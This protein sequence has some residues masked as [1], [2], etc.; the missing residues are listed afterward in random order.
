MV[1]IFWDAR[2]ERDLTRLHAERFALEQA[3]GEDPTSIADGSNPHPKAGQHLPFR[4]S[5][6]YVVQRI[7]EEAARQ[8]LALRSLS[9]AHQAASP[10]AIGT[11][12][13]EVSTLC[14]YASCKAW[15]SVLTQTFPSLAVRSLRLQPAAGSSGEIDAQWT[16]VLYVQD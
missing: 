5:I 9:I 15:Q 4:H 16:L 14:Q 13:L 3:I 12:G 7:G 8:G 10:S 2:L 1:S 6:D 11:V